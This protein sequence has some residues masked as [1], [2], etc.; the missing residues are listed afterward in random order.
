MKRLEFLNAFGDKNQ[1]KKFSKGRNKISDLYL[2]EK[3]FFIPSVKKS[4]TFLDFGCAAGNF[5][6]IIKK[7]TRIDK[8]TG[9]DI[10]EDMLRTARLLYSKYEFK[11][12]NGKNIMLKHKFDLV[13]SFGTLIYCLNYK[14][15]INNFIYFSNK[16]VNF[17][18]R[19]I[20]DKSIKSKNISHQIISKK[21]LI[22]F[23]YIIINFNEF[24]EFLLKSTNC[25]YKINLFGY[26]HPV[27][28][29]VRSIHKNVLMVSVLIDKTKKFSLN[30]DIQK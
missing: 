26:N 11:K 5:I 13:Y 7:L 2:S 6:N 27:A 29:D 8:F 19:L 24:L 17:D 30:I 18:V 1:L 16:Y 12:F 10:S 15:I 22:K 23:P 21:P 3:K 14:D 9:L 20:F 25:K 4:R 28:K